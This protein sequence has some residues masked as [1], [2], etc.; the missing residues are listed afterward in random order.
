MSGLTK[1]KTLSFLT[2]I[3]EG[4]IEGNKDDDKDDVNEDHVQN[5]GD[6]D[7]G[8]EKNLIGFDAH[9]GGILGGAALYLFP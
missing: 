7:E 2:E 1:S 6:D 8:P 4:I 9:V 3:L 5:D